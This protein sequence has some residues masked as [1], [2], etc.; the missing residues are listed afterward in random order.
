MRTSMSSLVVVQWAFL[1]AILVIAGAAVWKARSLLLAPFTSPL[2]SLPGPP[3]KSWFLGNLGQLHGSDED[4]TRRK[5]REDY[6]PVL[7]YRGYL[8]I[9]RLF[10]TDPRAINHLLTHSMEYYKPRQVQR[11]LS[12]LLGQG[13]LVTEGDQHRRQR[14]I[15]N[16]AFGPSQIR[17]LTNIF[18]EKS[19][20][21][22]DVWANELSANRQP[23]RINVIQG[24]SKMTLDAIGLVG[25]NYQFNSLN[26]SGKP[27]ELAAAFE[28]IF[29]V[30][31]VNTVVILRTLFP[32]LNHI[33]DDRIRGI[34]QAK[35]TMRRIGEQL[36]AEKKAAIVRET[37]EKDGHDSSGGRS[38]QA[39]DL[40]T[41][42]LK[43]NMAR[44]IPDNQRLSDEDV[45][46]QV[47]TF[48][49]AGH[50]TTTTGTTWCLY[51]LSQA[52]DV[53]KRLREELLSVETETPT[54]DELMALPYLD[55]VVRETLRLYAPVPRTMRVAQKDDIIPL[56]SPVT[57]R[58][59][60]MHDHIK[61]PAG[62]PI[63]IPIL[64]LN[65]D[66]TIWGED[67][68][69]FRPERWESLPEAV[70]SIPGVWSHTLTFLGGQHACIGYRFSLVEMKALLFTLVRAFEFEL[71][72]S[73]KDIRKAS[74]IVQRPILRSDPTAGNQMPLFVRRVG[75]V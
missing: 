32:I 30:P 1:T 52:L 5:W 8:S 40:L 28:K 21:L 63:V 14:K 66:K 11:T 25:F 29:Q 55:A 70:S 6:G 26:P 60:N 72:V 9:P 35:A 41:L 65:Q 64:T 13:L 68:L 37:T 39:R 27:N 69:D 50:E 33:K 49:V 16:P 2:L 48:L 54:M 75:P 15:M 67:A 7:M 4:E 47:P 59:G 74:G 22:R 46:A 36:V 24:L 71:A 3:N 31:E 45:L 43:A 18:V 62:T 58:C 20:E 56:G 53:Q 17:E 19:I 23:T 61:I 73:L 12:S 38:L 34:E 42:L 44:D 51:A 10:V 57:D